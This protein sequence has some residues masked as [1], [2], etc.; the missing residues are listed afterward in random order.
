LNSLEF[1]VFLEGSGSKGF[2]DASFDEALKVA[3]QRTAR[4]KLRWRRLPLA[5]RSQNVK[6]AIKHLAVR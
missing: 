5:A 4:A 3:M 1:V 2:K 6:D